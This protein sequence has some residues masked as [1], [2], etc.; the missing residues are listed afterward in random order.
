MSNTPERETLQGRFRATTPECATGM[1]GWVGAVPDGSVVELR[2]LTT[3]KGHKVLHLRAGTCIWT[4]GG[5]AL[6]THMYVP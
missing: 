5:C 1:H 2:S 4:Y 6:V 3:Q